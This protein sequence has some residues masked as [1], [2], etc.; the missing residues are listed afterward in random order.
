LK[1]VAGR[2]VPFTPRQFPVRLSRRVGLRHM[3]SSIGVKGLVCPCSRADGFETGAKATF[4]G[5]EVADPYIIVTT[6]PSP[7]HGSYCARSSNGSGVW[8]HSLTGT[9]VTKWLSF[10]FRIV[11]NPDNPP[12]GGGSGRL[13]YIRLTNGI[14]YWDTS[15]YVYTGGAVSPRFVLQDDDGSYNEGTHALAVNTWYCVRMKITTDGTNVTS[16]LYINGALDCSLISPKP[17]YNTFYYLFL[18][19]VQWTLAMDCRTAI[20]NWCEVDGDVDPTCVL[21]DVCWS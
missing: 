18:G 19:C 17:G 14:L 6:N 9:N 5:V 8:K 10:R 13:L 21:P 2:Q 15:L 11:P 4:W 20:D 3:Q 16:T 7:Y 12:T 1:S